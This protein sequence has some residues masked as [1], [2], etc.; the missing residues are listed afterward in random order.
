MLNSQFR[1]FCPGI[2]YNHFIQTTITLLKCGRIWDQKRSCWNPAVW[3]HIIH[4]KTFK[5]F[6]G[7]HKVRTRRQTIQGQLH[8]K[9]GRKMA[10]EPTRTNAHNA[11]WFGI[12]VCVMWM[13]FLSKLF[14]FRCWICVESDVMRI[15]KCEF[16]LFWFYLCTVKGLGFD[17]RYYF[18]TTNTL[19][20]MVK[21]ALRGRFS[22]HENLNE[23]ELK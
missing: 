20:F 9:T 13:N 10:P 14:D 15:I 11:K 7:T 19:I 1:R 22:C 18:F 4:P 21:G 5:H 17:K 8:T 2:V 12:K 6:F 23:I 16:Q 3:K